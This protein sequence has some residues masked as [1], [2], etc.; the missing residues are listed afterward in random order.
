MALQG[1]EDENHSPIPHDGRALKFLA[2]PQSAGQ[3][4][5]QHLHFGE[6]FIY[7]KAVS[8]SASLHDRDRKF[9]LLTGARPNISARLKMV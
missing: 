8:H 5:H 4:F 3:G 1:I 9:R 2:L 6:E 7:H